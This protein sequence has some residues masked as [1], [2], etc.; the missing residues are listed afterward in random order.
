[1]NNQNNP[2]G[3]SRARRR[4]DEVGRTNTVNRTAP[5]QNPVPQYRQGNPGQQRPSDGQRRQNPTSS[6]V[7]YNFRSG[8]PR[9]SGAYGRQMTPQRSVTALTEREKVEPKQTSLTS[10]RKAENKRQ[11]EERKEREWQ[12]DIVRVKGKIDYVLLGIIIVLLVLGTVAVFS[13]SYPFA[14]QRMGSG[15]YFIMQ[16][17]KFLLLGTAAMVGMIFLPIKFYKKWAPIVAYIISAGCLVVVLFTGNKVGEAQRWLDLGFF[18]VQPSELMK[19][20]LV[21]I[22]AWYADKYETKMK[23]LDFGWLSFRWNTL[24]PFLILGFACFLVLIGKHL[25][26][27][28][29][30][31]MIGFFVLIVAGCK[32][33][34]LAASCASVGIPAVVLFLIRNPYAWRRITTFADENADKLDELYQTTQSL[35]AIGNGGLAGVGLGESIQ[36]HG[37]LDASHTDFIFSVWCEETGFIGAV[38]LILLFILFVWRGYTVAIKAPDRFTMLTAFGITTHVGIQAFLN[39]MV[40]SDIIMN[41][42][43]PL[44]FFSYGGSSLVVLMFEMGILLSIS[45]Q[46]YKK[47]KDLEREEMLRR[48]GM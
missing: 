39:M 45:R 29:I 48:A 1:M 25:S 15:T 2:N 26:G 14:I 9:N 27:T 44:P 17:L 35:Y 40:S 7:G 8:V 42:G 43:I 41:T 16:Q 12:K 23:E 47:K 13:A 5:R 37:Y 21:L 22:L 24:Y 33:L 6:G 31:G 20:S 36:K 38:V 19:I 10:L 11:L 30:V 28:I 18:S 32:K 4:P 46:S 34:W 3:Q